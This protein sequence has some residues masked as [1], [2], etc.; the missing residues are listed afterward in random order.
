MAAGVESRVPFTDHRIV[1]LALRMS[2]SEH[3]SWK[4]AFAPFRIVSRKRHV[5]QDF[6]AR[7]PHTF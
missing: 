3:L 1:A 5:E 2:F 4:H 6:S 7:C